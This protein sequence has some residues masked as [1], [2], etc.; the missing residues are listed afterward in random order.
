[1]ETQTPKTRD[2]AI[3]QSQL[4]LVLRD[5]CFICDLKTEHEHCMFSV[6]GTEI[7]KIQFTK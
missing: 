6:K 3:K 1:M 4:N 5:D 7:C 2:F